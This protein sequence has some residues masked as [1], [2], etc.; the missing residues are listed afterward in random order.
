MVPSDSVRLHIPCVAVV[1]GIPYLIGMV[2]EDE[3]SP[4]L[5]D[6]KL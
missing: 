6:Q 3:D 2:I 4:L 5:V 1:V